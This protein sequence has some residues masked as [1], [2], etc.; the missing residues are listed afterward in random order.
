MTTKMLE[1]LR[2]LSEQG[3]CDWQIAE[4]I[5]CS[6]SSVTYWR[7]KLGLPS[8]YGRLIYTVYDSKTTQFIV[9]G[10]MEKCAEYL[11]VARDTIMN[12]RW[13]TEHGK[14]CKYEVYGGRDLVV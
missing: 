9:E 8:S 13:R 11:G 4:Q 7:Y 12:Y 2:K 14:P 5:G 6:E 10:S 3:L 1:R